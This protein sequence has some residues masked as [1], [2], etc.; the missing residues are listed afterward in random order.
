MPHDWRSDAI[1][2]DVERA[3]AR[4]RNLGVDAAGIARAVS[5]LKP[6]LADF[7]SVDLSR[8]PM[9]S[10]VLGMVRAAEALRSM[11]FD[12]RCEFTPDDEYD[13]T[14]GRALRAQDSSAHGSALTPREESSSP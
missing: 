12:E 1:R 7:A 9:S 4:R 2:A 10:L 14:I 11:P 13:D 3:G 8:A 5:P 6:A